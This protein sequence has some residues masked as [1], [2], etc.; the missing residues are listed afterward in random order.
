MDHYNKGAGLRDPYLSTE[1]EPLA[2]SEADINDFV[3]LMAS[4]TSAGYK[5]LGARELAR[6]RL[7]SQR[8]R[9]QRDSLRALGQKPA[10]PKPPA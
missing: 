8:S 5:D 3:A 2:L 1:I 7:L 6:Q 4:L 10:Q 9:P